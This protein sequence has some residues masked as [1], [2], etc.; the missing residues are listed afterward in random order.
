MK[1]QCRRRLKATLRTVLNWP[2]RPPSFVMKKASL[3]GS[4]HHNHHC[5][6]DSAHDLA[7]VWASQLGETGLG[8][9]YALISWSLHPQHIGLIEARLRARLMPSAASC[10]TGGRVRTAP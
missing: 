5:S 1:T 7:T 3:L 2:L 6:S 10:S 9:S 8:L 4:S